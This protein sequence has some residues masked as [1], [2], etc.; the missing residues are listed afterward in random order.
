MDNDHVAGKACEAYETVRKLVNTTG[1][2]PG[3][4]VGE[5]TEYCSSSPAHGLICETVA[6]E[7]H[8]V[9][10]A[11]CDQPNS[12]AVDLACEY[13]PVVVEGAE[14]VW[15]AIKAYCNAGVCGAVQLLEN[16]VEDQAI[17]HAVQVH[18]NHS[19]A[20]REETCQIADDYV[21]EKVHDAC[22]GR[23]RLAEQCDTGG[24]CDTDDAP[25]YCKLCGHA[26]Q[27]CNITSE[28][29]YDPGHI[30]EVVEAYC[31][32]KLTHSGCAKQRTV[33]SL[34]EAGFSNYCSG[35]DEDSKGCQV[36]E[37][38]RVH[39][40]DTIQP[41]IMGYM[42]TWQH[43]CSHDLCM[44]VDRWFHKNVLSY[45]NATLH[46]E[47]AA[48]C[49]EIKAEIA[50]VV[51]TT[52]SDHPRLCEVT[53]E[54]VQYNVSYVVHKIEVMAK[55]EI[56]ELYD[57]VHDPWHIHIVDFSKI[58]VKRV[59]TRKSHCRFSSGAEG[60]TPTLKLARS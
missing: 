47:Q 3:Q 4:V 6:Y 2:V 36:A 18:C 30:E 54:I 22:H 19:L 58:F 38:V 32:C 17:R 39:W 57:E 45:C 16:A 46:P 40:A 44:T 23:G 41:N 9:W 33:C 10:G 56:K 59:I 27:I 48:E 21:W 42:N 25:A 13:F 29:I 15:S 35:D 49:A 52:C 37:Y 11:I 8:E 43:F 51:N 24:V 34:A 20:R 12:T 50:A 31:N 53:S 26:G 60:A 55:A 7:I 1:F 14:E 5:I 28:A